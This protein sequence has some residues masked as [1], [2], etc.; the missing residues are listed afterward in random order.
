MQAASS[1]SDQLLALMIGYLVDRLLVVSEAVTKLEVVLTLE[2]ARDDRLAVGTG[3][4]RS[5]YQSSN[6]S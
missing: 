5:Q 6:Q 4:H 3:L 2:V 1:A